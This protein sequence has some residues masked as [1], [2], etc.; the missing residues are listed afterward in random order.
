MKAERR[1]AW[2]WGLVLLGGLV[3][4]LALA[5]AALAAEAAHGGHEGIS[6]EKIKE[7]ILRSI[8]FLVFAALLIYILVKKFPVKDF[9]TARSQEIA[10]TLENL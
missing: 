3:L 7:F 4:M 8:N 10:Q 1:I 6:P 2:G 9:F 5:G